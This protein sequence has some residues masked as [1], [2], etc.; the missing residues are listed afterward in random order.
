MG[1]SAFF[2]RF[3]GCNLRCSFCDTKLPETWK[4]MDLP[5]I[6]D[7]VAKQ[8]CKHIVLTGGEPLIQ[9][10]IEDLIHALL[11]EDYFVQVET[12]G[13]CDYDASSRYVDS[14]DKNLWFTCSPKPDSGY[15]INPHLLF[16]IKELKYIVTQELE[17]E[18]I[19][20]EEGLLVW[21]QPQAGWE[22]SIMKALRLIRECNRL[23]LGIQAHKFWDI[24]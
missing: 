18:H 21:L 6:M 7:V 1:K 24:E 14:G 2:I 13:T 5:E 17:L 8:S 9:S 15:K 12:N 23:R 4:E 3:Y 11:V 22:Y 20:N 16:A 10:G 19:E